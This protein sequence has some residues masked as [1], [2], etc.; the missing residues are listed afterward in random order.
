MAEFDY[1]L[2]QARRMCK[3]QPHCE[4]CPVFHEGGCSISPDHAEDIDCEAVMHTVTAWA[5]THPEPVY[6]SWYQYQEDVF[7]NHTRWVCPM[8]FGV[9]CPAK[10]ATSASVCTK[11]RNGSISAEIAEKL[12]ISPVQRAFPF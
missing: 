3:A 9:E 12:G 1:I 4:G 8:A 7:P 11:C 5:I 2:R 6:P 10:S